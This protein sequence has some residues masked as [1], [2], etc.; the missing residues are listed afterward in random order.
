[1]RKTEKIT[2]NWHFTDL[3]GNRFPVDIPHTWNAEDG[4]DGGNDY[5]RGRCCYDTVFPCPEYREDERIYLEFR[6]IS[7]SA[8]VVLNGVNIMNHDGGYSAFRCDITDHIKEKNYLTVYAD[9]S[10]NRRVYPQRADFTFYGGIYRDVYLIT[11]NKFHFNM[12]RYADPGLSIATRMDGRVSVKCRHNVKDGEVRV[13]IADKEGDIVAQGRGKECELKIENV[14]LWQGLDDPYLYICQAQLWVDGEIKDKVSACFGVREFRIDP[15]K[16]FF[17]NGR[18]YP[19]RGVCRHQDRKGIGNALLSCHHEEDIR[20]IREIGANT[21]RLAHYQQDRYFYE[22]CDRYGFIVWAEIPYIS[23]HMPKGKENALSQLRE[24]IIQCCNHPSIVCWGL[25]NE[26]TISGHRHRRDMLETHRLL[27]ETAHRLDPTRPTAIACYA[28]CSPFNRVAHI[29]DLVSWNLYFGWYTPFLFLNELWID[30]FHFLFPNRPLGYSEYGCEAMPGLH[31]SSPRRGDHSEEYQL[32]YHEH[33]LKCFEKRPFLWATHLW[34][35][36]DFAADARDQGG[37]P[38]MNHKGL[39]SFD[40]KIKKDAFYLY[41]AYW[42][43]EGFVHICGKRYI[44]RTERVTEIKVYSNLDRVTLL[45]NGKEFATKE[46]DKIFRF[47][48]PLEDE[49]KVEAVS[50]E[51]RDSAVFRHTHKPRPEYS[52]KKRDRKKENWI[53]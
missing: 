43:R 53:K 39:V 9:N 31:S 45:V 21:I 40:R 50:G 22:L 7:S 3:N 17:L 14:R 23:E 46:Q 28:L 2:N 49:I 6:G 16:G 37:E 48:V 30:L 47:F 18:S 42:S 15:Q 4:Q 20:L 41:K 12:D 26:I 29:T 51:H 34:N 27:N 52:L 13:I 11:V 25:S 10:V 8:E 5:K 24:L 35:M 19:L 38:G 36:F 44:Y 1:M 32:I 33:M